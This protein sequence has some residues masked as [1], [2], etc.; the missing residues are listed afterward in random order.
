MPKE[1]GSG[2]SRK[3]IFIGNQSKKGNLKIHRPPSFSDAIRL[4]KL[5]TSKPYQQIPL[6]KQTS[7]IFHYTENCMTRTVQLKFDSSDNSI[8]IKE[9][10]TQSAY[11]VLSIF[12][13]KDRNS[14][15]YMSY[16]PSSPELEKI[17][18]QIISIL[19]VKKIDEW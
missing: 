18:N 3:L 12:S 14:V 11:R 17:K 13:I 9:G 6:S 16:H 2:S 19:E 1:K 8:L 5:Q 4:L 7:F 10:D 15:T